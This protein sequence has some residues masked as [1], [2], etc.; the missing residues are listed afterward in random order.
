V[1][2]VNWVTQ[3]D[4]DA[5]VEYAKTHSIYKMQMLMVDPR[6]IEIVEQAR[7]SKR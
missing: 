4:L 1:E 2:T 3:Q 6:I 7:P 5:Y